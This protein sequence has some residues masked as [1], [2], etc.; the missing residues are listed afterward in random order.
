MQAA[1]Y[2]SL[3][4]L[5]QA[6]ETPGIA[7]GEFA[8]DQEAEAIFEGEAGGHGLR[9]LLFEGAGHAVEAQ[10]AQVSH[11]LL[12]QHRTI[13]FNR[14]VVVLGAAQVVVRGQDGVGKQRGGSRL[15]IETGGEDGG[16]RLA[17]L[18][19][20][21]EGAHAAGFEPGVAILAGQGEQAEASAIA[22]F[23]MRLGFEQVSDQVPGG[24]ADGRC[25][26]QQPGW[27]PFPMRAMR[28]WHVL[29]DRC[30]ATAAIR[31][32]V[33]GYA[34]MTKQHLDCG[35]GDAQFDFLADQGMRHRVIVVGKLDV[36]IEPRD[37]R[38]LEVGVLERR[39]LQ[40]PQHR[41][42]QQFEP[43]LP[44]ALEF[45]EGTLIEFAE[46]LPHRRVEFGQTVKAQCRK[47]ARIQRST[48]STLASTLALSCGL[49][50]RAGKMAQP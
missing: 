40:G 41:S 5:S 34:L 2:L 21:R 26:V 47:R 39:A 14:S 25:P 6:F 28:R 17:R 4:C 43:A 42:I 9:E 50:G 35:A 8:I 16:D 45:L 30:V 48:S 7:P 3:A 29:G 38:S 15:A 31:T 23:G 37:A 1:G 36:V 13:S 12:R 11:G 20:E 22:L 33:T 27:R 24:N 18:G 19:A 32:G 46:Q 10:G 44:A 49:R